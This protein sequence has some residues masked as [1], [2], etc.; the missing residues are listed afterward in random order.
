[1]SAINVVRTSY[2]NIRCFHNDLMSQVFNS[3]NNNSE[4][5]N[6]F[7]NIMK[8]TIMAILAKNPL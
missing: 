2:C 8:T 4:H 7:W 1:M 5:C 6:T 3:N